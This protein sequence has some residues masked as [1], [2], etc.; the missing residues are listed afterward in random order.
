MR[1]EYAVE[2]EDVMN[3]DLFVT[4]GLMCWQWVMQAVHNKVMIKL[5][6]EQEDMLSD[7]DEIPIVGV[8]KKW[9]PTLRWKED[10]LI[11]HT[12]PKVELM[13]SAKTTAL[14]SFAI[15]FSVA[16]KF[17]FV[18]K[19]LVGGYKL[20]PNLQF[21]LPNI[22][23]TDST[24]PADPSMRSTYNWNGEHYVGI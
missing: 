15:D 12:I 21:T 6:K 19:T 2:L 4:S 22:T 11:L 23:Y 8:K 20:G 10:A 13:N 7:R 17:G 1:K 24:E 9:M 5:T 14:A 3:A 18:V 16:E